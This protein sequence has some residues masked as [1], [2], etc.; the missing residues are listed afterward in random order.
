VIL[1]KNTSMDM[2]HH[3]IWWGDYKSAALERLETPGS[4]AGM[5]IQSHHIMMK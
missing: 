1:A 4:L 3:C 5:L 2:F